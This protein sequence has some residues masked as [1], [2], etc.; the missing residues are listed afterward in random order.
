MLLPDDLG[1]ALPTCIVECLVILR[2]R[3]IVHVR[4]ISS[5][6]RGSPDRAMQVLPD[7][8]TKRLRCV[9]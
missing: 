7:P 9:A 2:Y 4:S 6:N 1:L 3:G 5:P 8:S